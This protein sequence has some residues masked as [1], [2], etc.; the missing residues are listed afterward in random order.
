M[1]ENRENEVA[2]LK[3][4]DAGLRGDVVQRT[5]APRFDIPTRIAA[6][7]DLL[8]LANAR[9]TTMPTPATP[10]TAVAIPKP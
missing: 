8:C 5:T 9:T 4:D 10:C 7:G 1:A 6:D 3:I 2:S